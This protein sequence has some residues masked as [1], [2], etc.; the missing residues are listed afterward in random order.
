[1]HRPSPVRPRCA[2]AS[3]PTD[4]SHQHHRTSDGGV[5]GAA[6]RRCARA[7]CDGRRSR[8]GSAIAPRAG[9]YG[10]S[11][12]AGRPNADQGRLRRRDQ[13]DQRAPLGPWPVLF[14]VPGHSGSAMLWLPCRQ[15]FF[16]GSWVES[17]LPP[18]RPS[19]SSPASRDVHAISD[20]LA[21]PGQPSTMRRLTVE[22]CHSAL[23]DLKPA[24]VPVLVQAVFRF[25]GAGQLETR[26]R[27]NG[28]TESIRAG[29]KDPAIAAAARRHAGQ[30]QRPGGRGDLDAR[31]SKRIAD[32]VHDG[33]Q[34]VHHRRGRGGAYTSEY[35][36]FSLPASEIRASAR[37]AQ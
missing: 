37:A 11:R 30:A 5:D 32:D 1:M 15:P 35:L 16:F 31:Y 12:S 23:S 21:G 36:A 13:R 34:A 3:P 25:V 17:R 27:T 19:S 24:V 18:S 9:M 28:W 20:R 29:V 26:A 6:D 2:D 8:T 7:D 33:R 14:L 22:I 10:N 4:R